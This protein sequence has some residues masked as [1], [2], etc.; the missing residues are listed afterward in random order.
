MQP[1][2]NLG[3]PVIL[4]KKRDKDNYYYFLFEATEITRG[5]GD[6]SEHIYSIRYEDVLD[7]F[8]SKSCSYSYSFVFFK[9]R[10]S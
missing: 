9:V 8:P 5:K 3:K 7:E 10:G 6:K 4:R 2:I 1:F